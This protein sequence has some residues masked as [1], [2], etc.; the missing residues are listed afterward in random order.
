MPAPASTQVTLLWSSQS[1]PSPQGCPSGYAAGV[2][3]ATDLVVVDASLCPVCGRE[4]LVWSW[5]QPALFVGCG[6]GAHLETQRRVCTGCGWAM[7]ASEQ[8][9]SPRG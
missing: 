4:L 8:E 5:R 3:P 7:T 2:S 9:V 1:K 6:Y